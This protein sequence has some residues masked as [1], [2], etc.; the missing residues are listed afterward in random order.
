[1]NVKTIK[2]SEK[3]QIAIPVEIRE[4]ASIHTGDVLIMIQEGDKILL[5]KAEKL[6]KE[7]KDDF[8]DLLL[9]SLPVMKKLWD[10]KEDEIWDTL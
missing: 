4:S 7:V 6:G 2:V 5:E 1:M 8:R 10:N 9:L 3:G